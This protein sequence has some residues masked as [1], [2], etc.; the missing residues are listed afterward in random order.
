MTKHTTPAVHT[1]TCIEITARLERCTEAEAFAHVM[2][3]F[4]Y[5]ADP[6]HC[7]PPVLGTDDLFGPAERAYFGF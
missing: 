6:E 4:A 5:C 7:T 3:D 1:A 2:S